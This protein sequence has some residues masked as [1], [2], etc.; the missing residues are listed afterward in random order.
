MLSTVTLQIQHRQMIGLLTQRLQPCRLV[1]WFLALQRGCIITFLWR[2]WPTRRWF[3]TSWYN[4][5]EPCSLESGA[6]SVLVTWGLWRSLV[7]W[8]QACHKSIRYSTSI[9]DFCFS[10]P[11]LGDIK[12]QQEKIMLGEVMNAI[13][14]SKTTIKYIITINQ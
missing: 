4:I 8:S 1:C 12:L 14:V 7:F 6:A 9:D 10:L 5:L 2:S 11:E 13:C 3:C